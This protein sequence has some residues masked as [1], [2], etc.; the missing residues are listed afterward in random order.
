MEKHRETITALIIAKNEER[1]I[2]ECIGNVKWCDEIIVVDDM[3]IDRT[4]DIARE[5]GAKVFR[6]E[7]CGNYNK[8]CEIGLENATSDWVF[9]IDADERMTMEL[10]NEILEML[11]TN[12]DFAAYSI[13]RKNYFLGKLMKHG[14]WYERQVKLF[15]LKKGRYLYKRNL[16]VLT[17]DGKIGLLN[18][19]VEHYPFKT[20][21]QFLNRQINYVIFEANVMHEEEGIIGLDKIKYNLIIRPLKLF[22]KIYIKKQGFRDG[23]HGFIFS[24]LNAW[25]YFARWAIYYN[26]YIMKGDERYEKV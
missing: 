8:Q 26:R 6:H 11:Y 1:N 3:S 2:R 7:S 14:G 21:S 16:G 15:R 18:S 22:F 9:N 25:R 13:P 17:V 12:S 24:V 4:P 5:L 20:I 19:P 10:K 23:M